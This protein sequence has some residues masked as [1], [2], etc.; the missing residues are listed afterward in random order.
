MIEVVDGA[1]PAH[2]KEASEGRR[3]SGREGTLCG[4]GGGQ[5]G[6]CS[7][8]SDTVRH[9]ELLMSWKMGTLAATGTRAVARGAVTCVEAAW[10]SSTL[11]VRIDIIDTCLR[12]YN[13]YGVQELVTSRALV[14]M[15]LL[16]NH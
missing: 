8:L 16:M 1:G 9:S 10:W 14:V 5:H 3:V 12:V 15:P 7:G 13:I 6:C 4:G 2:G 11:G